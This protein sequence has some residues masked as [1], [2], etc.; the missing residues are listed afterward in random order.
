MNSFERLKARGRRVLRIG[1][2]VW[3]QVRQEFPSA[4]QKSANG[5][6]Q[7]GVKTRRDRATTLRRFVYWVVAEYQIHSVTH[8]KRKH[9]EAYCKDMEERRLKPATIVTELSHLAVLFTALGKSQLLDDRERLFADPSILSR[10]LVAKKDKS[11]EA[12]GLDFETIYAAACALN[13]RVA[14]QLALCWHFGLRAQEAWCFRPRLSVQDGFVRVKWG[15]K[16]GRPRSLSEPLT[17]K[18]QSVIELAK[19]FA[20]TESESMVPRGC[21]LR[22]WKAT[23]YRVTG[24]IGLTR[25]K[26]GVTPH[27]LRHSYAQRQYQRVTRHLAPVQGGTLAQD[28]ASAD[29]SAREIV[30]GDMGHARPSIS[31]AYIGG[32][33]TPRDGDA[34]QSA[35]V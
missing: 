13:P 28:D 15:T 31:A 22:T 16:G 3:R 7:V 29:R 30:S 14:V 32:T 34:G 4:L 27:S 5:A 8:L 26:S 33:R 10:S 21:S 6:R 12:A 24:Q 25:A 2:K 9:V 23:F 19:T 11:I 1:N 35:T 20:A 18:Q 17:D